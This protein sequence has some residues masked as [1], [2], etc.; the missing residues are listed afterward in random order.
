MTQMVGVAN[1]YWRSEGN[2]STEHM[3]EVANEMLQKLLANS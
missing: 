1:K 2:K 3:P